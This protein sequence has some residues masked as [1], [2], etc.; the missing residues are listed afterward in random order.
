[1]TVPGHPQSR[2][3][4]FVLSLSRTV[5]SFSPKT[6]CSFSSR[7]CLF[8][9]LPGLFVI[10]P[11]SSFSRFYILSGSDFLDYFGAVISSRFSLPLF[12]LFCAVESIVLIFNLLRVGWWVFLT[13][14][15]SSNQLASNHL[16]STLHTPR[17]PHHADTHFLDKNPVSLLETSVNPPFPYRDTHF[18]PRNSVSQ[19]RNHHLES[20]HPTD[21]YKPPK[22]SVSH[23]VE[24]TAGRRGEPTGRAP[25]SRSEL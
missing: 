2:H 18:H 12:S 25:R 5:C 13:H 19:K 24:A 11:V 21:T 22:N 8:F 4:L 14:H 15:S 6:L 9:L 16:H 20:V 10:P 7:D 23:S 17:T 1:M 3:F